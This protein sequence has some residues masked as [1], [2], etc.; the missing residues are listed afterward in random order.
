MSPFI[1]L[2]G[3]YD[4]PEPSDGIADPV[5]MLAPIGSVARVIKH[6]EDWVLVTLAHPTS[7]KV[8]VIEL[9]VQEDFDKFHKF[10]LTACQ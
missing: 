2:S 5:V 8:Y 6:N 7:P 9:W 10:L 1:K 4:L 3:H